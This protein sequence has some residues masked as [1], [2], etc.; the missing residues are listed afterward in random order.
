M[1]QQRVSE[2]ERGL[3]ISGR[4]YYVIKRDGVSN[5]SSERGAKRLK[6]T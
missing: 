2:D 1:K 5:N 6:F 3:E 4:I